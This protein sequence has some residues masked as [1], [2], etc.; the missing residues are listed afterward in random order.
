M[1]KKLKARFRKKTKS[2]VDT[3]RVA[4]ERMQ[5]YNPLRTLG[6]D[7]LRRAHEEFNAGRLKEA[8][9]LWDAI[10]RTDDVCQVAAAKRKKAVS[11]HGYEV[12]YD[13]S[14][15]EAKRHAEAL[16]F[17][18][19]K[20]VA[21]R[22][23]DRNVRGGVPL[24]VRQMMDAEGK[25]YANHEI[26]WRPVEG[27]L[28]AELIYVPLWYFENTKG[29]MRLLKG[30]S[31][32]NGEEMLPGE[33]MTTSGSGVMESVA[34]AYMFKHLPLQ[35]WL[36]YSEKF[37]MPIPVVKT[38]GQPGSK[39]WEAA[40][41]AAAALGACDGVV[42]SSSGEVLFPTAGNAQNLPYPPL[43]ERM[44]R[45]IASLWRG[46]D[47]G[48]ISKGDGTGASLQQDETELLE[49]DDAANITDVLNEQLDR[50]VILYAC[51][52]TTPKAWVK[53][54]AGVREDVEQDLKV[55][56][57]LSR[58]GY[59]SDIEDLE[60][61]YN[62]QGLVKKGTVPL[63][64]EKL[65]DDPTATLKKNC[66]TVLAQAVAE[67]MRPIAASLA[68]LLDNTSDEAFANELLAWQE[69]EL[70]TLA[71]QTMEGLSSADAFEDSQTAALLNGY[72]AKETGD[73]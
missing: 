60:R 9:K 32:L 67:D 31:D 27:G 50:F 5:R 34:A 43:I 28:T 1:I 72:F 66:R 11:R 69:N 63:A 64:N 65:Q 37:G 71:A 29:E 18:Y 53:I 44:D 36:L 4:I 17:F 73:A 68:D 10:E 47:L 19:D 6:P 30:L 12:I 7:T 61:R 35:D 2:E 55:D 20:L 23:D 15:A 49:D 24:L 54:K 25:R 33:W 45:A 58:M 3:E 51:G 40:E 48:T 26:V 14:D 70:P 62:R 8:S 22:A 52:S 59:E 13:E 16:Q 21:T 42:I 41:D 38:G 39:E 46:A 56:E 57:G